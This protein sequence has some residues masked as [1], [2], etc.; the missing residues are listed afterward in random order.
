MANI[1]GIAFPAVVPDFLIEL[2][3]STDSLKTLQE[4]MIKYRTNGVQLG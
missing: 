3:S 4:K 1:C 2:I